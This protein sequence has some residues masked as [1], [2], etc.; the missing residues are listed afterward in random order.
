MVRIGR[1]L[2]AHAFV[3]QASRS[4]PWRS[5]RQRRN[6]QKNG[7]LAIH[8]SEHQRHPRNRQ[9]HQRSHA[10]QR[11]RVRNHPRGSPRNDRGGTQADTVSA[12]G[13][14]KTPPPQQNDRGAIYSRC[15]SY[16]LIMSFI[17]QGIRPLA[18]DRETSH[19]NTCAAARYVR[20]CE[21]LPATGGSRVMH[22]AAAHNSN[23]VPK[24]QLLLFFNSINYLIENN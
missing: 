8:G 16:N 3:E 6:W 1:T 21:R 19:E 12:E 2:R 11:R 17:A 20:S 5:M 9:F 7:Q 14:E 13:N 23:H 4:D 22:F 24:A 18:R 15:R 10:H